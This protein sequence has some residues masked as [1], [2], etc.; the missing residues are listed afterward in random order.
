MRSS[1]VSVS[2]GD[3]NLRAA[4][5]GAR[6]AIEGNVMLIPRTIAGARFRPP[7]LT[8]SN[9]ALARSARRWRRDYGHTSRQPAPN[10]WRRS[11]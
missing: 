7:R 8:P 2:V 9:A 1:D 11:I 10:T 5:T 6:G 4:E 3:C